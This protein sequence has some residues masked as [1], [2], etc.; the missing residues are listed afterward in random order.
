MFVIAVLYNG[1]DAAGLT[2]SNAYLTAN[3]DFFT[4]EYL[5]T[6]NQ[7]VDMCDDTWVTSLQNYEYQNDGNE[8]RRL[9]EGGWR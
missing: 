3:I 6:K 9:E 7:Q 5:L 1:V 8:R 2:G 4:L